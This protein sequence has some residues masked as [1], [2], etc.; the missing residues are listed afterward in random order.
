[1]ADTN[2]KLKKVIREELTKILQERARTK[3]KKAEI[4][5]EGEGINLDAIPSAATSATPSADNS[6]ETKPSAIAQSKEKNISLSDRRLAQVI[7]STY[8]IMGNQVSILEA[9]TQLHKKKLNAIEVSAI[10][11]IAAEIRTA[12]SKL[13]DIVNST[14]R[15]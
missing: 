9:A 2:E 4:N 7:N 15:R 8:D 14:L 13:D 1:M 12:L 6:I 5:E 11:E 3:T 10:T